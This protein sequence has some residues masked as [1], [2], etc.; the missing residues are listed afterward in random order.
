M[1]VRN[2][3]V[4][5]PRVLREARSLAS[6]G[7][8]VTVVALRYG[9]LPIRETRDGFVVLRS[10]KAGVLAGPTIR[11]VGGG[12]TSRKLPRPS[13]AVRLR[14][15]LLAAR[16]TRAAMS[17]PADVY[18]AHDLNTLVPAI[19]AARRHGARVVYDAHELYPDLTGL[20][21]RE[22]QRW[23]R[24]EERSIRSA[25][26]V[27]V[28]SSAL[29]E[30]LVRRYGIGS[31]HVVMNCPDVSH[32]PSRGDGVLS[33]LRREGETLVV[34]SG[35]YTPNRGLENLVRAADRLPGC[36]LAM[37]GW[38]PLEPRLRA[39]ASDRVRF[40]EPVAP[41]DVVPTLAGGDVGVAPGLPIGLNNELGAPNKLFEYLHAGLAVA[42][43]D[44]PQIGE[45]VRRH[46]VGTLFDASD[47]ESIARAIR[48]AIGNL[49]EYRRRAAAAAPLYTWSQ[50]EAVLLQLY[51]SL[52]PALRG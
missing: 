13:L 39:D 36:R 21:P 20:A 9:D 15:E 45:I 29:G 1:L 32:A 25:D 26:E 18:H 33:A 40:L 27:V 16:M 38:G 11:S 47:P 43:S 4:R 30:E 46:G 22:S 19:A 5:D 12:G 41:D 6:S 42:A 31:P 34:Y 14:D 48:A 17:V 7:Y 3:F 44:L 51:E 28:P 2:A 52:L 10:V 49:D 50:Q 37:L 24:V 35:G 8:E 23:R